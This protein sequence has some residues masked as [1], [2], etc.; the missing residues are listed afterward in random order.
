VKA[1]TPIA[2]NVKDVKTLRIV[3]SGSNF[4]N[5]SGHAMLANAHVSQ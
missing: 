2:I 5:Y 4:T 1:P 3:V